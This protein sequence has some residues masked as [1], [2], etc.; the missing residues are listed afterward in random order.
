MKAALKQEVRKR[1]KERR[2]TLSS[3]RERHSL[4]G[5]PAMHRD[6]KRWYA[7]AR[8]GGVDQFSVDICLA[9]AILYRAAYYGKLSLLDPK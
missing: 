5:N 8:E 9:W 7:L 4:R 1:I 3:K 2:W 6:A